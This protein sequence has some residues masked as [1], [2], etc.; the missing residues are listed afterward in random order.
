MM[1]LNEQSRQEI[2]STIRM[3]AADGVERAN[4]GHPGAPMGLA[5]I[6]FLLWDEFLR[7]DPAAPDWLGRDRFVLS[8]GHASMLQYALLHLWG[9]DVSL[10]DLKNFRQWGS[11]TPGHPEVGMTPGIEVTTGPLGQ[12]VA[13]AV[14]M[15]LAAKMLAARL[16][17]GSDGW[18]PIQQ[19]VFALCSDGD[20]MEGIASEAASMAAHWRLDNLVWLY[21]D[22]RITIDGS[23]DLAF[24]ED[25][26][27][28]FEGFGWAVVAA[29]GHDADSLRSALSQAE[30]ADVPALI[31][32]RTHIGYG[33]PNKVD[34]AAAH[35]APLGESEIALTRAA[36]DW[37]HEPFVV[38]DAVRRYFETARVRK[39]EAARAWSEKYKA[40]RAA[41]PDDA[42]ILDAHL[43]GI[44]PSDLQNILLTQAP[45]S[46]ATRKIS[47]SVINAAA[48]AVPGIVGGSADLSG[49]NGAVIQGAVVVGDP[50]FEG[51]DFHYSGR[52]IHF[53]IREHAMG[54]VTNGM[55]L[56]GGFRPFCATF[57]VFSDYLRPTIRLAALSHLPN[58]FVFTHDSIF[59]GEDG[60]THQPVEHHWALRSIPGAVYFRPADGVEVAMCWSWALAQSKVP[61][62]F[63]LTRQGLPALVRD[64]T[65]TPDDVLRGGYALRSVDDPDVIF[66]AT[67]SEVH[68]CIEAA[69]SLSGQGIQARVVSMPSVELFES[70]PDSYRE[71]L[72]PTGHPAVVTV[73]AGITGPWRAYCGRRGLAI[74]LDRFGASAPAGV[75]A[76]Q[77]GFTGAQIAARVRAH[78]AQ[79]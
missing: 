36:L 71:Q 51:Q 11:N 22:N 50:N 53:G 7:F 72:I 78:L 40:W 37:T 79:D 63:G 9:Y 58:L 73:E 13:N 48:A 61:V 39:S 59:L 56:H 66:V 77:F 76:E 33:S 46:G 62:S 35:G 16:T 8:C 42:G 24:S 74:G 49:S 67:G 28:R 18:Q 60:P 23:T 55:L 31:I 19:R 5:D 1:S 17:A 6:A 68:L 21:D 44:M 34:T 10:D 32:C 65:C 41:H 26:A 75:L 69:D 20:L 54:A 45:E 29:D 57:L 43:D 15:A 12:G 70:Q 2:T 64:D 30:A 4:S 14:G 38:P 52:Q 47:G 3:L 27:R 25:V